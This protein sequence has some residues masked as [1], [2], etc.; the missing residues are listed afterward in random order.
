ML[1]LLVINTL[2]TNKATTDQFKM[3]GS[4]LTMEEYIELEAEK[5]RRRGQTFN[6]ETATYD[7]N[8]YHEDI[9]YFKD[10]ETDFLI[11][12]FDD[13]LGSNHKISSEPT[14]SP[15][16]NND[17]DFKISFDE[18]DNEDYTVIY[19]KNLFSY[20]LISVND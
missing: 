19:D 18:S 5:A 1:S 16:D 20:K 4:K 7:K 17:F 12:I 8:R 14:V 6:W 10:F 11:I 2:L 3:D 9:N 13:P 15:L